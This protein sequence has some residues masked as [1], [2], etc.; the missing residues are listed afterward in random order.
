MFR[1]EPSK[2]QNRK[3]PKH[4][5]LAL[6]D[7]INNLNGHLEYAAHELKMLKKEVASQTKTVSKDELIKRIKSIYD[8]TRVRTRANAATKGPRDKRAGAKTLRA[9]PGGNPAD[10]RHGGRRP[11]R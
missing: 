2:I 3:V 10:I 5:K 1:T 6:N 11:G 7:F 9:S 8:F 4:L